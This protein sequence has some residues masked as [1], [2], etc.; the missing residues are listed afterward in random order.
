MMLNVQINHIHSGALCQAI[1]ERLSTT[2]G[3]QS[4]ELPPN[5][6]TLMAQLTKLDLDALDNLS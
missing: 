3:P 1:G 5:L 2:L 4:N 6:L